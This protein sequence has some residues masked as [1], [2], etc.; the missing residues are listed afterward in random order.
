MFAHCCKW[1]GKS[2]I[3]LHN[4]ADQPCTVMLKSDEYKH[5]IDLFGDSQYEPLD[6]N[7]PSIPLEAYGY[8]WFRVK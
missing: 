7:S 5:L 2:A 1:E 4:L 6:M 3:A 8:R